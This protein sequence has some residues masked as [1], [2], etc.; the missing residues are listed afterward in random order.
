MSASNPQSQVVNKLN[1]EEN[2]GFKE[3]VSFMPYLQD[4]ESKSLKNP[5]ICGKKC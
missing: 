1:P 2:P 5:E 4:G 3:Q